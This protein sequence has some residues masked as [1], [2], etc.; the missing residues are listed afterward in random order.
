MEDKREWGSSAGFILSAIGSAVGL[1][2][3]WMFPYRAGMYGGGAFLLL[4]ILLLIPV[5]VV[6]LTV[7]WTLGRMTKGGPIKAFS[8]LPF[9]KYLGTIPVIAEFLIL[10]FYTV[11]FSWIIRFFMASITGELFAEGLFYEVSYD[12]QSIFLCFIAIAITGI[13]VARGISKGIERAN[14]VMLPLLLVLMIVLTIR[15]VTLPNSYEGLSFYLRPDFNKISATAIL[16]ATSQIFFSLTLD[17]GPMVVYGSYQPKGMDLTLSAIITAAIDACVAFMAGLIIFPAV[18]AAGQTPTSGP[19][20]IF[21]TL[22]HVFEAIP[23]G[24]FFA[25]MFFFVL[26]LA[27][28]TTTIAELE[29]FVNALCDHI[30]LKRGHA[31]AIAGVSVFTLSAF[32]ALSEDLFTTI[33]YISTV[34]LAITGAILA[35]IALAWF[36]KPEEA[37]A[38]LNAGG[39]IEFGRWWEG[40]VKYVYPAILIVIL[41]TSV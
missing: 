34:Y 35:C 23:A 40:Y 31:T 22:P 14:K 6:G 12:S 33:E 17:G 13:I 24:R 26:I 21:L 32:I 10:S 20:L 15:S 3:I 19:A 25:A 38:E 41:I 29:V 36:H 30:G 37:R 18:F 1:G 8:V 5:G 39:R 9:G 16:M 11:V 2:N 4:F 27:S 28:F 7:E